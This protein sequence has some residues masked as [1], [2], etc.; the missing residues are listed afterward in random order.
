MKH[1]LISIHEEKNW[2]HF[3]LPSEYTWIEIST[4]NIVNNNLARIDIN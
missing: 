1:I 2:A 3:L 4:H